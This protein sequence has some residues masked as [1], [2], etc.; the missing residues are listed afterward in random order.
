M[1]RV[2][3]QPGPAACDRGY[4]VRGTILDAACD[5]LVTRGLVAVTVDAVARRAC[6]TTD[7]IRRWWP[8]EEALA[9]EALY[10]EWSALGDS[11]RGG[12]CGF[13]YLRPARRSDP[14]AMDAYDQRA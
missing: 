9:V 7:A 6:V 5:L 10:H 13:G 11:I 3:R 12:A 1:P 4:G 14:D 8:T 2:E